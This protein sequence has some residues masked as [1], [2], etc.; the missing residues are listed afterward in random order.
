MI[1]Q[2]FKDLQDAGAMR[3]M[4]KTS[5]LYVTV[6]SRTPTVAAS[7]HESLNKLI[8]KVFRCTPWFVRCI[9]PNVEK[10]P[11]YFDEQVVLAQLRY[12]GMLE[13]IRIRKL[14]YPIRVRFHT[15]ADR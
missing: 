9:K 1:S 11:M 7:F 13:T 8:D 5:G 15:F 6:K 2:M 12:T 10:A 14:G 3:T 4:N